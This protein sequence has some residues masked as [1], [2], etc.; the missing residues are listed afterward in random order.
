MEIIVGDYT[1]NTSGNIIFQ[2]RVVG[3]LDSSN[4][5]FLGET[6]CNDSFSAYTKQMIA[7]RVVEDGLYDQTISRRTD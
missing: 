3:F 4:R 6:F 1:V 2:K 7:T 5:R